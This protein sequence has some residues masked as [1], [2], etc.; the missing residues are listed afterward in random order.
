M[1]GGYFLW[2]EGILWLIEA[3]TESAQPFM[4]TEYAEGP[5]LA[6]YI[7]QHGML[8]PDMLY[9]LATGLADALTAIHAGHDDTHHGGS[10]QRQGGERA[11]RRRAAADPAPSG[12]SGRRAARRHGLE[13]E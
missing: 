12:A 5:S 10:G 6:E 1:G 2:G 9:G 4:V 8:S 3:D 11:Y 7:D 13:Q